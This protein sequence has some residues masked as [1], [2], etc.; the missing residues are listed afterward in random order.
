MVDGSPAYLVLVAGGA[1]DTWLLYR[2]FSGSTPTSP[3]FRESIA[4]VAHTSP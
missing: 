3:H 2:F 4:D 1:I